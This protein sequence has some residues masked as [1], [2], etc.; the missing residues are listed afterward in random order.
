MPHIDIKCYPKHLSPAEFDAFIKDLTSLAERHLHANEGDIS[1]NYTEI[2]ADQW[3]QL[4]WDREIAP[5]MQHLA[6]KPGYTM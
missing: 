5:Q 3:K 4:V 1:I 6:K 2:P